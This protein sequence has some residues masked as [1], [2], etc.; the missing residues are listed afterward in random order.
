MKSITL[1]LVLEIVIV[2]PELNS[3]FSNVR[4]PDV[5][6]IVTLPKMSSP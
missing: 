4:Y 6:E 2:L 3:Q 1:L 5:P